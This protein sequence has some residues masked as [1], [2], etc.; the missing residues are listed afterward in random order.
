MDKLIIQGPCKLSGEVR[1]SSAKNASLPI[2]AATILSPSKITFKNLPQLSDINFFIKILE[3]LGVQSHQVGS[4]FEIMADDINNVTADYDLVRKMRASVLVLGPLLA[5]KKEAIV[6]LPGGCAIGTRPVDIHLQGMEKL[7]AQ[8]E[9]KKGYIHAK[10]NGLIGA[11]ILLPFPSVG[12]TENLMMAAAMAQGETIIDNA[13]REPEIEDLGN[14]LNALG[15]KVSGHGSSTIKIEGVPFDKLV[16]NNISYEIIGDRIEAATYIISALMLDS[17]VKVTNINPDHLDFVLNTLEEMGGKLSKEEN[18]II[19]Y[20]SGK[21]KGIRIETAPYPGFP[22]DVQA[23]L[24]ALMGV[25]E[26]DS[27]ISENIF[28]NRFMHVPE[29]IRMGYDIEIDGKTASIKGTADLTGAPVMCTD[30]RASAALV[31]AALAANGESEINR[32]YHLDRGY[33]NLCK[34]F[35][36]LGANIKRVKE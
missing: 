16:V 7:G 33:E 35:Q 20:P 34:K 13:A 4:D 18:S 26:G 21:L 8:I 2:L 22:T 14:F 36:S 27:L 11:K 25:C 30:L 31:L 6:S 3:S 24:M 5:R 29:L 1:V 28:E 23:Q 19:V 12:A 10:T 17:E 15:F 32:I 9:I